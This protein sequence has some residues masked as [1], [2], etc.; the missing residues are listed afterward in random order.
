M[1]IIQHWTH[2]TSP[3]LQTWIG[4]TA[5]RLVAVSAV[6]AIEQHGP[7]LSVGTDARIGQGLLNQALNELSQETCVVVMPAIEIGTSDEHADFVGT[8]SLD[9]KTFEGVLR[10]YGEALHRASIHRWVII[11]AHGGNVASIDSAALMMRKRYGML[12]AKAYYPKFVPMAGGPDADELR[13]GLHGGQLETS[14][15]AALAPDEVR[16]SHQDDFQMTSP[17]WAGQAPVAWLAQDLNV[18]GVAG[19]AHQGNEEEGRALVK[20]YAQALAEVIEALASHP[21]PSPA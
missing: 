3:E 12:V 18:H 8:I 6:G 13:L 20:H 9:A 19:H 7:H 5:G 11:N 21:L 2:L 17:P 10:A 1:A 14:L 4:S 15:M 16:P